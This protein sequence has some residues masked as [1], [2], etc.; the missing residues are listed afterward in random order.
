MAERPATVRLLPT[1][2]ADPG[3]VRRACKRPRCG[4]EVSPPTGRSRPRV[5]CSDNCRNLYQRERDQARNILFEARRLAI[6]YEIE[7]AAT[8]A[9]P[10]QRVG[11]AEPPASL[12]ASPALT[13]SHLALSL[14]AQALESI[15]V[16]LQDGEQLGLEEAL[17][18]II[19]AKVEGDRLMR[20]SR[21][22]DP[23]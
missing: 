21:R 23:P 12:P 20:T 6:Q 8:A 2:Q 4:N 19:S 7:D 5:F 17:A 11:W 3:I 13:A 22:Q 10:P 14:I 18:R 15:R 9:D 1:R 16:D